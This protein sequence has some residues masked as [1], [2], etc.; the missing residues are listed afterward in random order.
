[1]NYTA[2]VIEEILMKLESLINTVLNLE[3]SDDEWYKLRE[4]YNSFVD[5]L[6]QQEMVLK[7][8]YYKYS[9]RP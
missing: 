3:D 5:K 7:P 1:M 2:Y 4:I 6:D 8:K 9:V